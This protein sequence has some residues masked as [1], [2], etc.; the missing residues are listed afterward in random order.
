MKIKRQRLTYDQAD[1][2]ALK[3]VLAEQNILISQEGLIDWNP[4]N[5]SKASTRVLDIFGEDATI[6]IT[7][8]EPVEYLRSVYIQKIQEGNVVKPHDFFVSSKEYDALEAFLP[9]RSLLRYDYQK[10]DYEHLKSLYVEKFENVHMVPLSKINTL[11]PFSELFCLREDEIKNFVKLLESAPRENKSYSKLAV[12]LTLKREA[13]LR[14]L[15]L[16]SCGSEDFPSFNASVKEASDDFV[17]SCKSHPASK[18]IGTLLFR[19]LRRGIR[20]WRW[21]M[22]R[23]VDRLYPYKKFALPQEVLKKFDDDLL[24]ANEQFVRNIEEDL[25][26]L[27]TRPTYEFKNEYAWDVEQNGCANSKKMKSNP[28]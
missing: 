24:L 26:M 3:K 21:W 11:Y 18:Q 27:L 13:I 4:R 23:V 17:V 25:D 8:R 6:V 28:I 10:L 14:Y 19:V 12:D 5:W 20:P 16:K 7:I 2:N 15:G 1:L 9:E 22:Q